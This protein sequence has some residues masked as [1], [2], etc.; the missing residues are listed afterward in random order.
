MW[1]KACPTV[2]KVNQAGHLINAYSVDL[3]K[4]H[5]ILDCP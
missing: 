2:L 5:I 3:L 1:A 4:T